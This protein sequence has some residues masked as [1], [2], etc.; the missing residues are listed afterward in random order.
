MINQKSAREGIPF[1]FRSFENRSN[2]VLSLIA[3]VP[4][5]VTVPERAR[6]VVF[7]ATGHFWVKSDGVPGL[8]NGDITDGSGPELNPSA[9]SLQWVSSL[10]V[11]SPINC[12]VSLAFYS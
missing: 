11:V 6:A 5:Q 12:M 3:G 9:R 10:G 4:R 7:A 8:P 1:R 2:V